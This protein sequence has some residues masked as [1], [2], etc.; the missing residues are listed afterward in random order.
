MKKLFFLFLLSIQYVF[1]QNSALVSAEYYWGNMDPGF[2]NAISL[3]AEDG[4]FNERV[5]SVI[6]SYSNTQTTVG[7]ILFNIR[8][9]DANNKW[10]ATFK[11]TVYINN[12]SFTSRQIKLTQFEYFFGNFDPGEGNG[13]PIIA[14]DGVLD[15]AVET[16][17]RTQASWEVSS[18]AILFNI[19]AKDVSGI[20]GPL[21]KKTVFPY[22]ANP[23]PNLIAEGDNLETC[24]GI[25]VTLTYAGPNGYTPTWFDGSQGNTVTFTPTQA[26]SFTCSA[27][28]GNTTYTDSINITFKQQ[29]NSTITP[30]GQILVCGSSNFSLQS[31]TGAGLTYQWYLNGNAIN[32]G[33]N[34]SH[35]P[36][37]TGSYTV[38]VTDASSGCS[39]ISEPTVL[40]ASF[41]SQPTGSIS[42]CNSQTLSVPAGSNN[43]YQ[44]KK[45]G[46]NITSATS[47][48]YTAVESG[49]YA[50]TITNGS[51]NYTT[52]NIV[53]TITATS[54]PTAPT[55]QTVNAGSTLASLVASGSN[56]QWY[57]AATGGNPLLLNTPLVSGSTY[58]VSQTING[59]ESQRIPVAVNLSLATEENKLMD[60]K[61]Y[62][63]PVENILYLSSE[64]NISKVSVYDT[65]GKLV[66][67]KRFNSK[68]V[69]LDICKLT[70][71][72]YSVKIEGKS[73][74][75]E[76][77]IIKK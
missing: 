67:V 55:S 19:R 7:P 37:A 16:V 57:A 45:E 65:A 2:G 46:V 21:F 34:A 73:K 49:I 74:T 54:A 18:G 39:K 48:T 25:S 62:P 33:T 22:G 36:T 27:T 38:K 64:E 29:P 8:V 9:K 40:V 35:L 61:Y 26:G 77:K 17:L 32:G 68:S 6:A 51:C 24:P 4:Q 44:W 30:S 63:N 11:K 71:G 13:V 12:N 43:T 5:E 28:L 69:S 59:C 41:V 47:N 1:G 20:W 72:D 75:K 23:N 15:E 50:C 10:G 31:N 14:F 70:A 60:M 56:L 76:F 52:S 58:Y 3:S 66:L 42:S 53:L